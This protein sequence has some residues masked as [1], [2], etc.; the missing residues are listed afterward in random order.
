M[1]KVYKIETEDG[2]IY[3]GCTSRT[4]QKRLTGHKDSK[5][6]FVLKPYKISVC[7]E[8]KSFDSAHEYEAFLIQKYDST[9]P[10]KGYNK[11][12]GGSKY[13]FPSYISCRNKNI[14]SGEKNPMYGHV[15]SLETREK[16]RLKALLRDRSTFEKNKIKTFEQIE[17]LQNGKLNYILKN[18]HPR[19]GKNVSQENRKKISEANKGH[20]RW[21]GKKHTEETKMK[22][23]ESQKKWRLE[24]KGKS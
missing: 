4:L 5:K 15:Q 19:K 2:K 22:M 18:G 13:G 1:W 24:K 12:Y 8:T 11:R 9:N 21:L 6:L 20:K 3:I 14:Q 10:E 16:I 23:K 17:K 7:F